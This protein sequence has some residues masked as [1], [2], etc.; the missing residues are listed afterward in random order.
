MPSPVRNL[1]MLTVEQP[2]EPSPFLPLF[3]P[4]FED[5][6][7]EWVLVAGLDARGR[8]LC[9]FGSDGTRWSNADLIP[10]VRAALRPAEV[11]AI[12][13]AHNHPAGPAVPSGSDIGA[14]RQIATLCRMAN[15]RLLDHLIYAP[16]GV[17]SLRAM[18]VLH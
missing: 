1:P 13:V 18:G 2:A 10:C 4:Y 17:A 5:V 12:V 16:D 8:L 3:A 9:F 7:I 14:T 15:A 11:C 6:P